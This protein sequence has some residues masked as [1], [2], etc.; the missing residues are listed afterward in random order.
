M[1]PTISL[2]QPWASLI[3]TGDK[4]HETRGYPPPAKYLGQR[5]GIHAARRHPTPAEMPMGLHLLC[6]REW[7]AQAAWRSSLPRGALLGTVLLVKATRT[8]AMVPG[9]VDR[10][11]GDWS[12]GRWAWELADV[13]QLPAPVPWKGKQGWF[14]VPE[15]VMK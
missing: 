6:E 14:C 10:V 11:A 7:G 2:W 4:L 1:I 15:E 12:H 13:R 5:I 3:F 8:D 9:P